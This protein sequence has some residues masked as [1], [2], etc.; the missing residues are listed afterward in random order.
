MTE[1]PK[2]LRNLKNGHVY[3][4]EP[5][6][7]MRNDMVPHPYDESQNQ[8]LIEQRTSGEIYRKFGMPKS[9]FDTG[10]IT[11]SGGDSM[12]NPS[13]PGRIEVKEWR[14]IKSVIG[15]LQ[16]ETDIWLGGIELPEM[17]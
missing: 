15:K 5:R 17:R 7:A 6:L 13:P 10:E 1:F 16:L 4:F 8:F 3:T 2:R 9:H 14:D 12:N 11:V